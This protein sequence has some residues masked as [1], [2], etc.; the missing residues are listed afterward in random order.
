LNAFVTAKKAKKTA[1]N[2]FSH[3]TGEIHSTSETS[4][5]SFYPQNLDQDVR[6]MF[7]LS[8]E[9]DRRKLEVRYFTYNS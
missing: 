7:G 6:L 5:S 2:T 3:E 8:V 9:D 4:T 1:I